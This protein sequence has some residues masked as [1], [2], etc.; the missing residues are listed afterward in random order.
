M[1]TATTTNILSEYDFI[2][3]VDASGS[4]STDDMPGGR[5][6]WDAMQESL[7]MFTR[8]VEKFDSDGIGLVIFN[9]QGVQ[10]FD[11]VTSKDVAGRLNSVSPRSSTPLAE[12]LTEA[13]KLAGK[14]SKKDFILVFTDGAPDNQ[15][16]AAD[17]LKKAANSISAD[18]ELTVL[19]V[20]IGYDQQATAYLKQLDD[21]LRGAKFDVV[22]VRTMAEAEK[23]ATTTELIVA[24]IND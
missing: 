23:F 2:V 6:R 1:D 5:T 15:A 24:A 8:D 9:G 18:D 17:V 20:Q 13:L 7:L 19:F 11:G 4:M 21:N 3:C 12:A 14:S 22:D 10:S 16:A